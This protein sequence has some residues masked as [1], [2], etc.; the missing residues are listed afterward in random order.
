MG[1]LSSD[2]KFQEGEIINKWL[3]SRLIERNKNVLTA[4]TGPTGSGKS[5]QDLRKVELWYKYHFNKPFPPEN[6]CFSIGALMKRLSSGELEKGEV[7]IME[8]AG[9]NLGSLDFQSKVS[10]IFTYVLQ[11]FRSMNIAIFFNLP[12][13]SMLNK[14]ARTLIHVHFQ[15]AGIDNVNNVAVTKAYFRQVNQATGKVYNKH[16]RVK[17]NGV[18]TPIKKFRYNMPSKYLIDAYEAQKL[19]FVTD[20]TSDFSAELDKIELDKQRAMA[21][22][23]LT[24]VE[25]GVFELLQLGLNQTEIAKKTGVSC[26]SVSATKKRI[27]RK[28][29]SIEIQENTKEN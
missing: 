5:Y 9:A 11:A 25:R 26:A 6:I 12:Y 2:G 16:I 24:E 10:K 23:D 4:T 20:M 19:K 17:I 7:L 28:G 18:T 1:M 15:T 21:R 22:D 3:K 13:L 27:L 8:E 14:Q 29:F